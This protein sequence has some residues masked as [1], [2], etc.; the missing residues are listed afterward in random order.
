MR[1]LLITCL[2]L[3]ACTATQLQTGLTAAS[4]AVTD[5]QLICQVGPTFLALV[6][7]TGAAVLAKGATAEY[8]QT[9]CA[10]VNG[11]AVALPLAKTAVTA[12]VMP[13]S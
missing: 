11:I 13:P 2:A 5:G 4:Q 10:E 7:P 12:V 9:A 3:S 1:G 6:D 8:V